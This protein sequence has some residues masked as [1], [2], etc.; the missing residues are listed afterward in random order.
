M[1]QSWPLGGVE[2]Q[3]IEHAVQMHVGGGAALDSQPGRLVDYQG[4]A[5]TKE[6][7][8]AKFRRLLVIGRPRARR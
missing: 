3:R 6:H 2:A 8:P 5:V 7:A 4:V 1:H